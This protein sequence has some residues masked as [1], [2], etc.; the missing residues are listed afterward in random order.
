LLGTVGVLLYL[1]YRDKS[2][3]APVVLAL[4]V[5]GACYLHQFALAAIL[6]CL[7]LLLTWRNRGS[8][9]SGP[10]LVVYASAALTFRFWSAYANLHPPES[11]SF[12]AYFWGFP[13]FHDYL[14]QWLIQ[15]WPRFSV[16]TA[17]GL[18][19]LGYRFRQD[20]TRRDDLF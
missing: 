19:F 15:G 5:I 1:A 10:Y 14:L 13:R 17:G 6:F 9:T 11:F 8:L 18:L 12:S 3:R 20:R 16:V 2:E 4:P 7:Y